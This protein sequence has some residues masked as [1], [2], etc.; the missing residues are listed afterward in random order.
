MK[1]NA[2]KKRALKWKVSNSN[3]KEFYY[4]PIYNKNFLK[5]KIRC[6]GDDATDFHIRKM[7]EAG[8]NH[9]CFSVISIDSV[10][11]K[12]ENYYLKICNYIEKKKKNGD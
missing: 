7:H 12:D 1:H 11:K 5:T 3:K 4:E 2:F 6:Y 10:P 9:I 8:S